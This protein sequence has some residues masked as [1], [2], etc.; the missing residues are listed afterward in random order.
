[1]KG[2]IESMGLALS[3]PH[4]HPACHVRRY[5]KGRIESMVPTL[6][7]AYGCNATV[8]W[9]LEEQ[10]Y[11]PPTVNDEKSVAFTREIAEQLLGADKASTRV[12]A[13]AR[14]AGG[15]CLGGRRLRLERVGGWQQLQW[16]HSGGRIF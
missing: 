8:D 7:A 13:A 6:A 9:R 15:A 14:L 4:P 5:M 3:L 16:E 2:R 1:M 11:Y 12:L 10:P